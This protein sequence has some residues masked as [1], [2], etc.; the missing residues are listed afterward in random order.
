MF[1]SWMTIVNKGV[2][3]DRNPQGTMLLLEPKLGNVFHEH[4]KSFKWS[5][6]LTKGKWVVYRYYVYSHLFIVQRYR[7]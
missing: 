2:F 7:H 5:P 1:C 6:V 3:R 4:C